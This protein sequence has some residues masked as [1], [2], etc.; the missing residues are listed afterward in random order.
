MGLLVDYIGTERII[1]KRAPESTVLLENGDEEH[2]Q[3][4]LSDLLE[5]LLQQTYWCGFFNKLVFW[6]CLPRGAVPKDVGILKHSRCATLEVCKTF[7]CC[8]LPTTVS[9]CTSYCRA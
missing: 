7:T 9:S 6:Y 4:L 8:V 3:M 2:A 5:Q 1:L